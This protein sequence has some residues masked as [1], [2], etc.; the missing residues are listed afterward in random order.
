MSHRAKATRTWTFAAGALMAIGMPAAAQPALEG[1]SDYTTFALQVEGLAKPTA[2]GKATV[3]ARSLPCRRPDRKC[4]S[5]GRPRPKSGTQ[6]A[7][8][9]AC[10]AAWS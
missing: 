1:Y 7:S 3:Q 9:A 5:P 6:D 2:V 4:R 8:R 10:A